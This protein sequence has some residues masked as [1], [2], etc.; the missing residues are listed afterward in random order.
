MI[1]MYYFSFTTAFPN[2]IEGYDVATSTKWQPA[3]EPAQVALTKFGNKMR[4]RRY[5]CELCD[6]VVKSPSDLQRHLMV[7]KVLL[8]QTKVVSCSKMNNLLNF[9]LYHRFRVFA[10]NT[11]MR[12]SN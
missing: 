7:C 12:G 6:L 10:R 4:Q 8:G 9:A 2:P 5:P 1:M 3:Q 11:S